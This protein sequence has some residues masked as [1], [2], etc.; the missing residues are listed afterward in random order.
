MDADAPSP[1]PAASSDN[2]PANLAAA[3]PATSRRAACLLRAFLASGE[4]TCSD[5]VGERSANAA[6]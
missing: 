1:P 6:A 3:R 2:P 5:A 4:A